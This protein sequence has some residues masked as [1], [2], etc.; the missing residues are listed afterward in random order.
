MCIFSGPV[1][2]VSGTQIFARLVAGDRQILVYAMSVALDREV[3]LVLPLPV[4]PGAGDDAVSFLDLSG[5]ATFFDDVAEAFPE[6]A[7][8]SGALSLRTILASAPLAVHD[9]GAF[10]ASYV[11]S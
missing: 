7:V 6:Q 4:P 9:V 3:A 1:A 8:A 5:Y 10:V 11:P 2:Q